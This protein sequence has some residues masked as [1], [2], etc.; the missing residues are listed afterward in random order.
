MNNNNGLSLNSSNT[1]RFARL[2][3]VIYVREGDNLIFTC[4]ENPSDSMQLFWT[5]F[6]DEYNSCDSTSAKRVRKLFECKRKETNIDF[7]LKV[8]R[9]SELAEAP[10]FLPG[11]PVLFIGRSTQPPWCSVNNVKLATIREDDRQMFA[12][13]NSKY[14]CFIIILASASDSL[15]NILPQTDKSDSPFGTTTN[16][17]LTSATIP[18]TQTN[19]QLDEKSSWDN[20]RFLLLPGSLAFLTL[21]GMQIVVCTFWLPR[22]VKQYFRC[23][24]RKTHRH[25]KLDE[26]KNGRKGESNLIT[27]SKPYKSAVLVNRS[28]GS[29][30]V[31]LAGRVTA[32]RQM[33]DDI[34]TRSMTALLP[35]PCLPYSRQSLPNANNPNECSSRRNISA[36]SSNQLICTNGEL[37]G[38]MFPIDYKNSH[39]SDPKIPAASS[40]IFY[41]PDPIK[42][43]LAR[44]N[45]NLS[46]QSTVLIPYVPSLVQCDSRNLGKKPVPGSLETRTVFLQTAHANVEHHP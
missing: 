9:F 44:Y 24:R 8:S 37:P 45:P 3:N 21:V 12:V 27:L 13:I 39:S 17:T 28:V 20:Y 11:K 22:S 14:Q 25:E 34:G 6:E 1:F 38:R 36:A 7:I 42:S 32:D 18:I 31:Q 40:S 23:C 29:A 33:S 19:S 15:V 10:H 30:C 5:T 43:T 16:I 35:S 46:V 4:S 26:S 2:N 41:M